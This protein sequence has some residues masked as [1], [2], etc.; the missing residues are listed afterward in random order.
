MECSEGATKDLRVSKSL[1]HHCLEFKHGN[2]ETD[3]YK[4]IGEE[5]YLSLIFS[6]V[7]SLVHETNTDETRNYEPS[8]IFDNFECLGKLCVWNGNSIIFLHN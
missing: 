8:H 2:M 7:V 3:Q 1:S 5:T 4:V 6:F